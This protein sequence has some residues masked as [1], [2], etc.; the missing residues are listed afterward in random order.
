[1]HTAQVGKRLSSLTRKCPIRYALAST[2]FLVL[3][4]SSM[5]VQAAS[6]FCVGG[7][8]STKQVYFSGVYTASYDDAHLGKPNRAFSDFLKREYSVDD[9]YPDCYDTS[10]RSFSGEIAKWKDLGDEVIRTNW[11]Y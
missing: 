7:D 5:Q 1:M 10:E 3:L 8:I 9:A 4:L 11:T 2:A 6:Y